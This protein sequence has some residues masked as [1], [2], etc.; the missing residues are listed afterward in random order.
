MNLL[1]RFYYLTNK[2]EFNDLEIVKEKE[3]M[4]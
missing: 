1:P 4:A 3:L 2:H